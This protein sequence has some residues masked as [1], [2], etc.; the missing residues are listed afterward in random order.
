MEVLKYVE[1]WQLEH[2]AVWHMEALQMLGERVVIRPQWDHYAADEGLT[3]RCTVCQAGSPEPGEGA[4]VDLEQRLANL[5]KQS[6][7][8]YCQNCYGTGW[9]G[10]YRPTIHVTWAIFEDFPGQWDWT[11]Y[12]LEKQEGMGVQ[13]PPVPDVG[14]GD[15]IARVEEFAED[16]VTPTQVARRM[17]IVG[18][19]MRETLR[20]GP[21]HA[22][23][24]YQLTGQIGRVAVIPEHHPALSVPLAAVPR[25]IQRG[26]TGIVEAEGA[27]P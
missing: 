1:P 4:P 16:G 11:R 10:G 26:L 8:S 14:I 5:Y 15:I 2:Q 25:T 17:M 24:D 27:V 12:G 21:R 3:V 19:V 18:P 22:V 13:L 7:D 23:D 9:E 6:A 20:T